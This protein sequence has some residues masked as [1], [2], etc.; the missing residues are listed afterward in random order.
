MIIA[1]AISNQLSDSNI[2]A[3]IIVANQGTMLPKLFT[4]GSQLLAEYTP[5]GVITKLTDPTLIHAYAISKFMPVLICRAG[6]IP[7]AKS[8]KAIM[9]TGAAQPQKVFLKN[10]LLLDEVV[11]FEFLVAPSL[12]SFELQVSTTIYYAGTLPALINASHTAVKVENF[13]TGKTNTEKIVNAI[14]ALEM[15]YH[16]ELISE[17]EV[18]LAYTS[19]LKLYG[20]K[21]TTSPAILHASEIF[22]FQ[23]ASIA[24][25]DPDLVSIYLFSNNYNDIN[26]VGTLSIDKDNAELVQLVVKTTSR[27]YDYV[28]SLDSS[29]INAYGKNQF[30]ENINAYDD[31]VFEVRVGNAAG[32]IVSTTT[33]FGA[34]IVL[35]YNTQGDML[36]A[37]DRLI[38]DDQYKPAYLCPFGYQGAGYLSSLISNGTASWAFTPIGLFTNVNDPE[39]IKSL[40]PGISSSN[41]ICM[42]PHDISV[43][44]ADFPV[45]LSLEVAYLKKIQENKSRGCEFAPVME[46]QNG[47][48]SVDNPSVILTKSTREALLDAKI[49]SLVYKKPEASGYLNKNKSMASTFDVLTEE[50][51]KRLA[52]KINRDLEVLCRQFLGQYNN[53][54]TRMN[55]TSLL[56]NYFNNNIFNQVY[57]LD[58]VTIICDDTNNDAAMEASG[59]LNIVVKGVYNN[60]I[61]DVEIF[62]R[63][64]D[65]ANAV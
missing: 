33:S 43:S 4:K 48:L 62:H 9:S 44:T 37:L 22:E 12:T 35:K 1:P 40:K 61:Y 5:T 14:N 64:Y 19:Q 11:P 32:P 30:L 56:N 28:G 52:N 63:V 16:I 39:F 20:V 59:K 50:Q 47:T 3:G 13:T 36:I 15:L 17:G 60:T 6:N 31:I 29:Y 18:N 23:Y 54:S 7:T 58:R 38:D 25:I 45:K 46:V 53:V 55:V 41:A 57:K 2:A 49:M 24:S 42:A 8:G 34:S 27:T 51:N 65:V 26:Y 21:G 10:D